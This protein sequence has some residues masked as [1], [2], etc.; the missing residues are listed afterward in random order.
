MVRKDSLKEKDLKLGE[1]CVKKGTEVRNEGKKRNLRGK[2]KEFKEEEDRK[3][4]L[5][6]KG[7]RK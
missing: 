2:E 6:R 3:R 5:K 1:T 7:G 4:N